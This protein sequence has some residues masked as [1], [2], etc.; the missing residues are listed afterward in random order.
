[1]ILPDEIGSQH[2]YRSVGL[3]MTPDGSLLI[4]DGAGRIPAF[5]H[6]GFWLYETG[7]ITRTA[8]PR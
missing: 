2:G 7:A 3:T 6:D 8:L 5:E 1:M 4:G